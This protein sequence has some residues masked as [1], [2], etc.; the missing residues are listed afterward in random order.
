MN[1]SLCPFHD[2]KETPEQCSG[3]LEIERLN[4]FCGESPGR[5]SVY[6]QCPGPQLPSVL[7]KTHLLTSSFR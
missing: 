3:L 6:S 1:N 4:R 7:L 5:V 2:F